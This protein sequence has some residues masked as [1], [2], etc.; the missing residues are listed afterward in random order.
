MKNIVGLVLMAITL[1][2]LFSCSNDD[3]EADFSLLSGNDF[4]LEIDRI[5]DLPNV[6]FP[7]D[8]LEENDYVEINH[9]S[10]YEVSFSED[11][12]TISIMHD[13]ISGTIMEGAEKYKRYDLDKG[14]F[15]GGR[16]VIWITD[17]KFEAEYTVYGSGVPII[18]SERGYL[19]SLK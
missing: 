17:S 11:M 6:Q 13:S 10:E 7:S 1:P 16:F 18:R 4:I 14:L 2:L 3:Y 19:L 9:D 5:S 15:A 12:Q 8:Q